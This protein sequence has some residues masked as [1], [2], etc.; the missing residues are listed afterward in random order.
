MSV[1]TAVLA[2]IISEEILQCSFLKTLSQ[3]FILQAFLFTENDTLPKVD[4]ILDIATSTLQINQRG[5]NENCHN[6]KPL[7]VLLNIRRTSAVEPAN[8]AV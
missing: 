7:T 2:M 4:K 3:Q 8:K 1:N 5:T 6:R